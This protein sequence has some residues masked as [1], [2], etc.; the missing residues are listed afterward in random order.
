M[1]PTS[2]NQAAVSLGDEPADASPAKPMARS[3]EGRLED[4]S[5]LET[6]GLVAG[7]VGSTAIIFALVLYAI[8]P[9][10]FRLA[11][12]NAAFGVVGLVMYG[13]TNRRAFGRLMAGRSTT[14]VALEVFVVIGVIAMTAVVNYFAAQS[15]KEWDLTRD[16]LYTLHDQSI[17]VASTLER[18]VEVIGFFRPSENARGVIRQTVDLYRQHTD[19]LSLRFINP[20]NPP[21]ALIDKYDLNSKSPRIVVAADN[22]Q[23]AKLRTPTEEGV[24]NALIKVAQRAARK[25]YFLSGH[26]EPSIEERSADEGFARAASSLRNEG[27]TVETTTLIDQANV[28]ADT[29]VI[30]VA[31][32]RSALLPNEVEALKA[33]LDRGGRAMLLLEPGRDY[34]LSRIFRP[35]GVDIG[36]NLVIDPHPASKALGFGPD[37]PIIKEFEPHPITNKL[38]GS[39]T[40][41]QRVRSVTP[42]VN[43]ARLEV[44]VLMKTGNTAWGEASY[45]GATAFTRDDNDLA[46]PISLAV[47]AARNTSTASSKLSDEGRLVVVGDLDFINNRFMAMTGNRDLFLNAAN[48]LSGEEDRITIRPPPR[49]GDRLPLTETQQYGIMFFSVNLLPLLI[50]GIG[51]SVWA[52]RQ[53]Q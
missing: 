1:N 18:D 24:T 49:Y 43:L 42:R 17:Q 11:A 31:G 25:I 20:D 2:D 37:T 16:G 30:I 9:K 26:G 50:I 10:V 29:A 51:F 6:V 46:G 44:S 33:F 8:D 3:Q 52:L 12:S 5:A 47:A 7:V 36:D 45:R 53:R 28:P 15:P 40:I 4:R 41:F 39:A 27:Y 21:A 14:F 32:A 22:G 48:W 23:F 38:Q 34:G 35:Y 19:R 13:V